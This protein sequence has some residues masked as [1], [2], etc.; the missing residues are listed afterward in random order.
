MEWLEDHGPL[1]GRILVPGCGLGHDARALATKGV[2][3]VVGIDLSPFAVE[4]ARRL[5]AGRPVRFTV[6]DLFDETWDG[7]GGFDWVFEHT[8]FCA[9]HPDDRPRYVRAV[10]RL[11]K[12]NGRFLG[13]FFLNPWD[14]GEK[15]DGPPFG[16]GQ[17]ELDELFGPWF[18]LVEEYVPT[19][20]YPG[21][22]GRELVRLLRCNRG[23]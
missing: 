3:E 18:N 14:P 1:A 2:D 6:Q 16:T 8:C 19:Q 21:R 23:D 12:P 20:A 17:T 15:P 4:Q 7:Q 5:A 11:L 10:R 9:I 13:V 22:E